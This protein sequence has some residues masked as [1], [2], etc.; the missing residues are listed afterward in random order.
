MQRMAK[1]FGKGSPGFFNTKI[2]G[3]SLE[4]MEKGLEILEIYF[5]VFSSV[6]FIFPEKSV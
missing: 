1:F 3:K 6:Y 2:G 4:K 5:F